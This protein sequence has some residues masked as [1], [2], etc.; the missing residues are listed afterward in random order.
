MYLSPVYL[1]AESWLFTDSR[2][3]EKSVSLDK[4]SLRNEVWVWHIQLELFM[5]KGMPTH[6]G[7][8]AWKMPWTEEPGDL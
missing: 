1:R 2:K 7:I 4:V 6:S 3:K 5:E 8:L